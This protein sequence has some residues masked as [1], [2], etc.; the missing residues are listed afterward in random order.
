MEAC[1][2]KKKPLIILTGPT[3]VGKTALSI[4]LAKAVGGEI[5]SADSMQVYKGMD[6]GTA[7]ITSEEMDGVTHYLVDELE[8]WEEFNVVVFQRLCK[9]YM[10]RIYSKG[11][12][13]I[14]VGGTGFY[15]QSVLY[16]IDFT[17][18]EADTSYR[19]MLEQKAENEGVQKLHQELAQVDPE[20]AE[21]IHPNNVKKV[22]RALEYYQQTGQKI[23]EH[24]ETQRQKESPYDFIYYVLSLPREILYERINKRVDQ[25]RRDGLIEEVKQLEERG[26]TREM[27]SMQ[28]LGYK[29]ILDAFAGKCTMDEAFEKIKLETRH[30][31]KRQFTWFR[32]ER[33]VIWL[34]KEQYNSE[35]ALLA[36]CVDEIQERFR[37]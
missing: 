5:I 30:F 25:M 34:E 20:S 24:N 31:A 23:S 2:K 33:T 32:R 26:C 19:Q 4:G 9:K 22:I 27:V 35:D 12:I 1:K 28:G 29:E 18:N 13:P 6:V 14:I 7:K 8:P 17:E 36:Y 10:E 3:A 15:I 21:Q 11:K 37:I 16:D